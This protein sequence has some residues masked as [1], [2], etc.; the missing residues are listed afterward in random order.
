M[1]LVH[2]YMKAVGRPANPRSV[3]RLNDLIA[4]LGI[5]QNDALVTL[6][7][8]L[9][10]YKALY[11][12]IPEKIA[13]S[14]ER[15]KQAALENASKSIDGAVETA[16]KGLANEVS[17]KA[18]MLARQQAA[19]AKGRWV[20]FAMLSSVM[21]IL[22]ASYVGYAMGAKGQEVAVKEA[23]VAGQQSTFDARAAAAWANTVEGRKAYRMYQDG[24]LHKVISCGGDGWVIHDGTCFGTPRKDGST[25]GW[26]IP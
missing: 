6:L 18:G 15:A 10:D 7:F 16:I 8:V 19:A 3:Q 13:E 4:A 22:V 17:L 20:T 2:A 14:T 9:E 12:A 1:D 11:E 24:D 23:Y 21:V 25:V 5:K 26:R